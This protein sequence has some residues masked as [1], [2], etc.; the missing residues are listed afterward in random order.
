MREDKKSNWKLTRSKVVDDYV[1]RKLKV[2][3]IYL[4]GIKIS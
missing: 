3:T 1:N 4:T 2:F